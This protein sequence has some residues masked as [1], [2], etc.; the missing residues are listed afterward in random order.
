[1]THHINYAVYRNAAIAALPSWQLSHVIT[2]H[3]MRA[4]NLI[5]GGFLLR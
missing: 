2:T 4:H 1:M 5:Q 3:R